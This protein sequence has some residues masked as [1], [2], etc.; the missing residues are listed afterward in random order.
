[1]RSIN[2]HFSAVTFYPHENEN[3]KRSVSPKEMAPS[4]PL[5]REAFGCCCSH[6]ERRTTSLVIGPHRPRTLAGSWSGS[7]SNGG[8]R[9]AGPA[10]SPLW[11][12]PADLIPTPSVSLCP[13]GR[14]SGGRAGGCRRGEPSGGKGGFCYG[15]EGVQDLATATSSRPHPLLRRPYARPRR[16]HLCGIRTPAASNPFVGLCLLFCFEGNSSA[17]PVRC[18]ILLPQP[19]LIKCRKLQAHKPQAGYRGWRA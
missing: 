3:P 12:P 15:G 6:W 13:R 19:L 1:M 9:Q 10:G 4:I 17:G 8:R 18:G 11:H 14:S 7:G 5:N 16:Q 2:E